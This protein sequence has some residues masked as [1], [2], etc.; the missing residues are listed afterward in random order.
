MKFTKIYVP[1][2][3]VSF[4][5]GCA[6]KSPQIV[7]SKKSLAPVGQVAEEKIVLTVGDMKLSE[8]EIESDLKNIPEIDSAA[9]DDLLTQIINTKLLVLEARKTGVDKEKDLV[10]EL[11]TYN[12]ILSKAYL[13]DSAS[14]VKIMQSTYSNYQKEINASH[15]FIPVSKY[16]S[17]DDTLKIYNDLVSLRST[18]LKEN[19]FEEMVAKVSKDPKTSQ[20]GGKMGWFSTYQLIY[21]LEMAAYTTPK[22]SVSMPVRT[23]SGYHLVKVNDTRKN[24]GR[25]KVQHIFKYINPAHIAR[26]SVMA[27][28]LMDSLHKELVNGADFNEL[29]VKYSDDQTSKS[30]YGELPVF[31]IGTREEEAF[32]E[33]A[34]SLKEGAISAPIRSSSGFHIIKLISKLPPESKEEFF[35][36]TK[37]KL[38]TDSRGEIL[39]KSAVGKLK[40][41]YGYTLNEEVLNKCLQTANKDL[42]TKKWKY[43]GTDLTDLGLF[44]IEDKTITVKEFFNYVMDRQ[45]YEHINTN[46]TPVMVMKQFFDTFEQKVILDYGEQKIKTSNPELKGLMKNHEEE[47]LASRILND[48]IYEKSVADTLGQRKYYNE[49]RALFNFPE[50]AAVETFTFADSA[51]YLSFQ[52]YRQK[53]KP[54]QLMRGIQPIYYTKNI[55]DLSLEDQRKLMGLILI[56]EK[57]PDYIVEVGGHADNNE[58][59]EVSAARIQK[60]VAYLVSNKL[61]I[62]RIRE[63]DYQKS[64]QADRFDWSKNQRVSFQFFSNKEKDLIK[65]FNERTP[66]AIENRQEVIVKD[67]LVKFPWIQWKEGTYSVKKANKI[68]ETHVVRIVPKLPKTLREA[69]VEVINGYQKQLEKQLFADLAVKYPINLKKEDILKIYKDIKSN[70]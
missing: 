11:D 43:T 13:T 49:H 54:Y 68:I 51:N 24:S 23:A 62:T 20:N 8:K 47:L 70:N 67:D 61:S 26:D 1:I 14:L 45:L 25:V 3:I 56:M 42:L 15:I 4:L 57:N 63:F 48:R 18:I 40:Q 52:S 55:S 58:S 46:F 31:G 22:G 28:N 66:N 21:P 27:K 60:V 6:T 36:R 19:N 9:F 53:E 38:T 12:S 39:T 33:A 17:P 34:F 44:R 50:R 65:I 10:E 59:T 29:C 5:F 35:E 7:E 69:R 37:Y 2:F 16:A 64:K 41:S 32:E 30:T